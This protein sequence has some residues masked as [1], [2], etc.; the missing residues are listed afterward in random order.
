MY[1]LY[2]SYISLYAA[3]DPSPSPPTF[4]G[5]SYAHSLL[6]S[7]RHYSDGH[8]R[9]E[10]QFF[11][12][13][14]RPFSRTP[15]H[16]ERG[17]CSFHLHVHGFRPFY[18]IEHSSYN[19]RLDSLEMSQLHH[20]IN[21][22]RYSSRLPRPTSPD[23][24]TPECH[25]ASRSDN[26]TRNGFG[27]RLRP[28]SELRASTSIYYSFL[29][30]CRSQLTGSVGYSNSGYSMRYNQHVLTRFASDF[31]WTRWN[32]TTFCRSCIQRKIW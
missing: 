21:L 22:D 3:S 2:L 18:P 6:P 10:A 9:S 29:I 25:I 30:N 14:N 23:E 12:S 5:A 26:T 8:D 32:I 13:P 7:V 11:G 27:W 1:A 17:K 24:R 16:E 19:T 20:P 15:S 28:V 4:Q 31:T